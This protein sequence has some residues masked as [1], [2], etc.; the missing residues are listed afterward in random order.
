LD[1]LSEGLKKKASRN[2]SSTGQTNAGRRRKQ[3]DPNDPLNLWPFPKTFDPSR[4]LYNPPLYERVTPTFEDM[5]I[6]VGDAKW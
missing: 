2:V 1:A 6:E 3:V 4:K 5:R